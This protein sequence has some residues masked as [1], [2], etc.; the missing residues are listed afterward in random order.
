[1]SGPLRLTSQQATGNGYEVVTC[2]DGPLTVKGPGG[3]VF[4][5]C[6]PSAAVL[7]ITSKA[8]DL[9]LRPAG[10]VRRRRARAKQLDIFKGGA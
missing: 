4:V 10:G 8:G 3:V 7:I 2:T 5:R 9:Y 1:M 6:K